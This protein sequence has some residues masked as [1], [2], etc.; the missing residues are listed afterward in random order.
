MLSQ[1]ISRRHW[2]A[3]ARLPTAARRC[4]SSS[5]SPSATSIPAMRPMRSPRRLDKAFSWE[6]PLASQ[7]LMHLVIHQAWKGE[8]YAIDTLFLYMANMGW[9]S[10]MNVP[11]TLAMLTD[12]TA[13]GGYKIPH[14]IYSDAYYSE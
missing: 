2:R 5:S 10:A 7:G 12:K 1:P 14:I 9:N 3:S 8:P 11:N 4:R 6:A 13:D